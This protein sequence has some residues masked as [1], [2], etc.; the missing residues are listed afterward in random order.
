MKIPFLPGPSSATEPGAV[1]KAMAVPV[2]AS[3]RAKPRLADAHPGLDRRSS[4][5]EIGNQDTVAQ[6]AVED[7]C[8]RPD[9]GILERDAVIYVI[10]CA[11]PF[12]PVVT[13]RAAIPARQPGRRVRGIVAVSGIDLTLPRSGPQGLI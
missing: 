10:G 8:E 5:A 6:H 7:F 13:E 3:I 12:G 4:T 11:H 1:A 9:I 2:A